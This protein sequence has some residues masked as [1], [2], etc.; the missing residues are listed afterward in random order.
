MVLDAGVVLRRG[1]KTAYPNAD[2]LVP[3]AG[4][5]R[6]APLDGVAHAYLA[7][8]AFAALLESALHEAA[9]PDPRIYESLL[10][11]WQESAVEL[12]SPLRFI[13]LRDP[14]LDRLGLNRAQLVATAPTHY[15]CTRVWAAALH[16]R[17]IGGQQTH[18]IMWH[19]RQRELHATAMTDRPALRDLIV[20]VPAEVLVVWSPPASSEVLEPAAGGLGNLAVGP[21]WDYLADLA[22]LLGITIP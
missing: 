5:T 18:G 13:D 1:H 10:R 4:N 6:F 22:A 12:T 15:P 8:T 20:E 7:T 16:G 19:S 3:G 2:I 17:K 21:G 9:P 14:E 11:R